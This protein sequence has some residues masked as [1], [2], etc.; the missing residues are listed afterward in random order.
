[1]R[2]ISDTSFKLSMCFLLFV[3]YMYTYKE[4]SIMLNYSKIHNTKSENITFPYPK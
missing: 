2:F 4:Q 1:M 3:V